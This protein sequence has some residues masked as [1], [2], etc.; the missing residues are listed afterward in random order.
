MNTYEGVEVCLHAFIT[1]V[2]NGDSQ[3]QVLTAVPLGTGPEN[4]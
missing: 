1:A 4:L 3:F 2:L